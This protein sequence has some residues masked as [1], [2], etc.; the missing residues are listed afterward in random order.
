MRRL[1]A[2][3][4]QARSKTLS[5]ARGGTVAKVR[6]CAGVTRGL[7]AALAIIKGD[8]RETIINE[9]STRKRKAKG[10]GTEG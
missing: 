1:L 9:D 10:K 5:A 2:E 4:E 8:P 3:L 7:E 6:F